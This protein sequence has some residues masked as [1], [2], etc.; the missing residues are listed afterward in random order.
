MCRNI[1]DVIGIVVNDIFILSYC[2][3]DDNIDVNTLLKIMMIDNNITS[4]VHDQL[5]HLI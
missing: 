2:V 4:T 5:K 3:V 1:L